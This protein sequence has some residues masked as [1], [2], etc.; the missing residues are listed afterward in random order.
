MYDLTCKLALGFIPLMM[1]MVV[2]GATGSIGPLQVKARMGWGSDR[3][4]GTFS[5]PAVFVPSGPTHGM[6]GTVSV[7]SFALRTR[8]PSV[9]CF[10]SCGAFPGF[11]SLGDLGLPAGLR[12]RRSLNL[13]PNPLALPSPSSPSPFPPPPGPHC[14]TPR[15]LLRSSPYWI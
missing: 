7:A 11:H 4:K 3:G 9:G 15:W 8:T 2:S 1:M 10:C 14:K 12:N 6:W 13:S 5:S